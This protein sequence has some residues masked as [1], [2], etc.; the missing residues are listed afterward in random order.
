MLLICMGTYFLS[1]WALFERMKS[2]SFSS[3]V[4]FSSSDVI[5]SLKSEKLSI[6]RIISSWFQSRRFVVLSFLRGF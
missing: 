2:L 6:V 5:L 3:Y 4:P 1:G